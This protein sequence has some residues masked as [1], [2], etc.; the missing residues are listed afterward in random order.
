MLADRRSNW[1]NLVPVGRRGPVLRPSSAAPGVFGVDLTAG[2]A[3]ACVYCPVSMHSRSDAA[4]ERLPFDPYTTE[5]LAAALDA[6]S[7][8]VR[9]IVLSPQT[10][11]L[12]L[13]GPVRAEAARVAELVLSRGL[14]LVVMTRGRF[15]R[16]MIRLLAAHPRQVR[17]G[18]GLFS[19]SRPLVRELEPLAASPFGR[20]RDIRR[21]V[22]AGVPVDVRLE[23]LIPGLTDT[24]ENLAPLFRALAQAGASR[25]VA[26]YLFMHPKVQTSLAGALTNLKYPVGPGEMF[27]EGPK[28]TVGTIG[29]VRNLPREVRREG[30]ARVMS[31]GAEFGLEVT[32]GAAQ[33][34]DLPRN[35]GPAPQLLP[36]S[37]G[38][39]RRASSVY[40][41]YPTPPSAPTATAL[42]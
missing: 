39:R 16:R 20:V 14:D 29:M 31:W 32:T 7:A 30:L 5:A 11:P 6:A 35:P 34:P 37:S 25:V 28:A 21:L 15:S 33:N 1:P 27:A 22:T 38:S 19:L 9:T 8:E 2:C 26:H 23:P 4:E 17:V 24:R 18:V 10:D 12:P 13:L 40:T 36:A 3:H 42:S 41:G